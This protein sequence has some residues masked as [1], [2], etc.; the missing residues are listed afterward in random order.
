MLPYSF[1]YEYVPVSTMVKA[2]EKKG[3]NEEGNKRTIISEV[4]Q[5]ENKENHEF[6]SVRNKQFFEKI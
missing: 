6:I 2:L 3:P 5:I 4:N 1:L